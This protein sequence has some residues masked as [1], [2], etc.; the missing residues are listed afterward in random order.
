MPSCIATLA[1]ALGKQESD[2]TQVETEDSYT[3]QSLIQLFERD[4]IRDQRTRKLTALREVD[5]LD[6]DDL[7][8][9]SEHTKSKESDEIKPA[10]FACRNRNCGRVILA[11]QLFNGFCSMCYDA[12]NVAQVKSRSLRTGHVGGQQR[13][14]QH[15]LYLI[16]HSI[17]NAALQSGVWAE[18]W[19]SLSAIPQIR[20]IASV[21]HIDFA[22]SKRAN[23]SRDITIIIHKKDPSQ[24]IDP[25]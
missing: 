21:D 11:S 10:R 17:D 19:S 24:L 8:D 5:D 7:L 6:E 15:V 4:R 1:T 18:L 23:E 12:M 9:E 25:F 16:V 3:A 2:T 14:Y 13:Q 22:L 20:I